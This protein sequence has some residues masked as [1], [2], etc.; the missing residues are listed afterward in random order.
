[1]NLNELYQ[2][3]A[4]FWENISPLLYFHIAAVMVFNGL[5]GSNWQILNRIESLLRSDT[6]GRVKKILDE[7]SLRPAMPYMLLIVFFT[8][9]SIM[10]NVLG[11]F[12]GF[13]PFSITYSQTEFWHENRPLDNLVEIASYQAKNKV[14]IWEIYTLEMNYLEKYTS[15]YPEKYNTL[16][17]WIWND[18]KLWQKYY[19]L[20][21]LFLIFICITAVIQLI[22]TPQRRQKLIKITGFI[23][24]TL[25][26]IVFFRVKAEQD[27]EKALNTDMFFVTEQLKMDPE[28]K[29]MDSADLAKLQC[30]IYLDLASAKPSASDEFWASRL[31]EK[32]TL[33]AREMPDISTTVFTEMNQTL[34]NT[35]S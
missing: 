16:T 32:T 23:I 29:K 18:F 33:F 15:Q 9:L 24:L 30:N 17:N 14:E 20:A 10:N 31:L 12:G 19:Q 26:L 22:K 28:Q 1:M 3:I 27:V 35:C 2:S 21:L 7:F 8:Y 6:Y 5:N 4:S 13:G 11:M 25:I 34:E